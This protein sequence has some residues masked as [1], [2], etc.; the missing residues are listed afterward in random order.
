ME[1][2]RPLFLLPSNPAPCVQLDVK[3]APADII[4]VHASLKD[5]DRDE[6][7]NKTKR[8]ALCAKAHA[9]HHNRPLSF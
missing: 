2:L 5:R 9:A 8:L 1:T 7:K 4:Q 3:L 6:N